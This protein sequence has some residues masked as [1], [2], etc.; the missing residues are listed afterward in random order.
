MFNVIDQNCVCSAHYC[1]TSLR[2]LLSLQVMNLFFLI[3][4]NSMDGIWMTFWHTKKCTIIIRSFHLI[5]FC[6]NHAYFGLKSDPSL[7]S[8]QFSRLGNV[9]AQWLDHS[10]AVRKFPG[11]NFVRTSPAHPAVK[12]YPIS[13]SARYCQNASP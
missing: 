6:T 7:V 3:L 2:R 1:L 9:V 8:T 10:L 5:P 13:D 11:S 12:G 4:I